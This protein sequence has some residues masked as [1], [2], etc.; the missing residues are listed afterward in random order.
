MTTTQCSDIAP[1]RRDV[2][3]A[4]DPVTLFL[5]ND[6]FPMMLGLWPASAAQFDGN[7]RGAAQAWSQM[8]RGLTVSQIRTAVLQLAEDAD[9]QFA[10]RPAEVRALC[11]LSAP[12]V[13]PENSGHT[14]PCVSLRAIEMRAESAL[15][16]AFGRID[17]DRRKQ[18]VARISAELRNGGVTI[19]GRAF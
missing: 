14:A 12:Q 15:F 6:L 11:R 13:R 17:A 1:V 10:P 9:R 2:A 8:L 4:G 7:A 16:V 19:T 5:A 18:E 3:P